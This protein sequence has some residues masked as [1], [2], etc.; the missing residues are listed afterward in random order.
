M[1]ILQGEMD[2]AASMI[3]KVIQANPLKQKLLKT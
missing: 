2:A 1:L 3:E